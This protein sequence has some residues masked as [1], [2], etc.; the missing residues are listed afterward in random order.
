MTHTPAIHPDDLQEF[1]RETLADD[2]LYVMGDEHG[3]AGVC[4]YITFYVRHPP[5]RQAQVAAHMLEVCRV[6]AGLVDEPFRML[7]DDEARGWRA[8]RGGQ[9]P[10]GLEDAARHRSLRGERF[11]LEATDKRLPAD[12]ARWAIALQASCD[13]ARYSFL[14]LTFRR[15]WYGAHR[16]RWQSFVREAIALLQPAH[17]YSGLEIGNGGFELAPPPWRTML[18]AACREHLPGLE[19][20]QPLRMA[21]HSCN[22]D[23]PREPGWSFLLAPDQPLPGTMLTQP[24]VEVS[25]IPYSGGREALWVRRGELDP[26]AR[27][28]QGPGLAALASLPRQHPCCA[29]LAPG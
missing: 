10:R 7:R 11:L 12:S 3:A 21:V 15:R 4:P 8:C 25:S 5:E 23:G 28:A 17:C 2:R 20:D 27:R 18:E 26:R 16:E 6:F 14:K 19:H 29:E 13:P 1:I 9:L 22:A 24:G